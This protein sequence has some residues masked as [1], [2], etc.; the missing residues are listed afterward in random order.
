MAPRVAGHD[1]LSASGLPKELRF[2][3][4]RHT[5]AS[6]GVLDGGDI[7]RLSKLLG[8]ASVVITQK[9]HAHLAPDVWQQA[10]PR[11][12]FVMPGSDEIYARTKRKSAFERGAVG[13]APLLR[14]RLTGA[15]DV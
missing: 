10:Y 3:D 6:H 7:F 5:F 13:A 14:R 12:A 4:L 15:V 11:E 1:P 8:H 9:T 2:R